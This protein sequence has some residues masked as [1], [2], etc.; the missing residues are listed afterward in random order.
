MDLSISSNNV[1]IF[2]C[3]S[4]DIDNDTDEIAIKSKL[5]SEE[6]ITNLIKTIT[7]KKSYVIEKDD[8]TIKFVLDGYYIEL[9]NVTSLDIYVK[10]DYQIHTGKHTII[11]GDEKDKGNFAGLIAKDTEDS[12]YFCI[13]KD[14]EV[15]LESYQKFDK[16]SMSF[17]FGE[18]K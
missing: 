4:R 18:L 1:K 14:G 16:K 3:V 12:G 11:R 9:S 5:M 2:P 7:D 15:P 6:N 10:L 8:T 17:D 13:L